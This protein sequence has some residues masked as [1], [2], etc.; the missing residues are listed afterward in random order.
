MN[1]IF[2]KAAALG[3]DCVVNLSL[4]SNFG[5]HDGSDTFSQAISALTGPGRIVVASAGNAQADD[6]HGKLT[7]TSP[8]RRD[9]PLP[10]SVPSYTARRGQRSTTTS[11]SPA[12]TT[13]ARA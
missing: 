3:M 13:R 7:T 12:G 11:S 6:I 10:V 5:P 2:Q 9:G 4:G 1:Y 8:G